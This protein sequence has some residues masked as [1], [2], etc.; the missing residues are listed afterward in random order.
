MQN[1]ISF[2]CQ[3][4]HKQAKSKLNIYLEDEDKTTPHFDIIICMKVNKRGNPMLFKIARDML[5]VTVSEVSLKSA[6]SAGSRFLSLHHSK[7]HLN[8]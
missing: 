5:A 6:F 7:F 8:T 2:K 4:I 1:I 3:H